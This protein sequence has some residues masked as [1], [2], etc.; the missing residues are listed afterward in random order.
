VL[1]DDLVAAR[2]FYGG[3]LGCAEGRSDRDW[4]D[5]DQF[6][7][8]LVCHRGEK[9]EA[10]QTNAVDGESVPVPHF[11]VVLQMQEWE[12]LVDQLV[13]QGV[14]FLI[15]PC[16]RFRG[17]PGEQGTFFIFDPAG[18]ALEFKGFRNLHQLFES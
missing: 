13:A 3:V 8:Q 5:F 1:V 7:H 6:G 10:S 12:T 15:E 9:P 4:V 14:N 17:Q 11:G 18:N 2:A 16:I